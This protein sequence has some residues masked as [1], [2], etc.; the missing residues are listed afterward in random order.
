MDSIIMAKL[1]VKKELQ[2]SFIDFDR[3]GVSCRVDLAVATQDQLILLKE[4]GIDVFEAPEKLDKA[5]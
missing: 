3:N 5:K 1:V 2:E 4:L